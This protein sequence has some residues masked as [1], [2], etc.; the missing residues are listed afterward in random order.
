MQQQTSVKIQS[1]KGFPWPQVQLLIIITDCCL[2][3]LQDVLNFGG[4]SSLVISLGY[5]ETG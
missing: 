4:G 2:G 3:M 1:G 5:V